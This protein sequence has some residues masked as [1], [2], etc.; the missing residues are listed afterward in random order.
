MKNP[1]LHDKNIQIN[2]EDT[3]K[4]QGFATIISVAGKRISTEGSVMSTPK[5]S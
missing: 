2:R 1:K 5:A 4:I 3:K